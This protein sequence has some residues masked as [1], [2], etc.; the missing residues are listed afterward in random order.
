MMHVPEPDVL[1]VRHGR[2]REHTLAVW[3]VKLAAD[4]R[5]PCW[6]RACGG[7][8]SSPAVTSWPNLSG[9]AVP[10]PF[11]NVNTPAELSV[12]ADG[13][14]TG[15]GQFDHVPVDDELAGVLEVD[16]DAVADHRLDLAQPP[17]GPAGVTHEVAG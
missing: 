15:W 14:R 6:R 9:R 2:R 17:V 16:G 11:L 5:R 7:S 3:S 8:R 10:A 1:M 12:A 13:W 4:L